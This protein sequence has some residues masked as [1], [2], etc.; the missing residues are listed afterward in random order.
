MPDDSA[1]DSKGR[2]RR[3]AL[4]CSNKNHTLYSNPK[5]FSTTK[6]GE[7]IPSGYSMSTISAFDDIENK[8]TLYRK[9]VYMKKVL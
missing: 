7:H 4:S 2:K 3:M 9:K 6:I 1:Y 8:H 5:H